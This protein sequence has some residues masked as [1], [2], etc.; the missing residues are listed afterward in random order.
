[1]VNPII[2]LDMDGVLLP[3]GDAGV[4]TDALPKVYRADIRAHWLPDL[5]PHLNRLWTVFQP[6]WASWWQKDAHQ[7][8]DLYGIP[9]TGFC[10]FSDLY[11]EIDHLPRYSWKL[12]PI[13][14]AA[15]G[16]PFVWVDDDISDESMKWAYARNCSIPTKFVQTD[17]YEGL[18]VAQ[19]DEIWEWGCA[20][21]P[22]MLR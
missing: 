16:R 6:Y 15:K 4:E 19:L 10:H 3:I 13:D 22:N 2:F 5:I 9:P 21:D 8:G 18:T 11:K 12:Y 14:K 7:V 17:P 20:L 1:M